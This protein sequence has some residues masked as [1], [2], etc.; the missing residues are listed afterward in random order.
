MKSFIAY[1]R[2]ENQMV[3]KLIEE[4]LNEAAPSK[5]NNTDAADV[6]EIMLGYY[7]LGGTWSNFNGSND[8]K[9]Q[10]KEKSDKVGKEVA[11]VQTK[12]AEMMAKEVIA[13][14]R[15]NGYNGKVKQVWWTARPGVL[16]KAVGQ[17]VNSR[18]NPTDVLLQ[19][20]DNEFLG[21]SAKSTKT[22]GDIGFKNPGIGTVSKNLNIVLDKF[23]TEAVNKLLKQYPDLS[24]SVSTRKREIRADKNISKTA[25]ELGTKVLNSIRDELYKKLRTMNDSDIKEYLLNDWLDAK[26]AVYPRY[27]KVTGMRNAVKIEDPMANSKVAALSSYDVSVSKIGNDSVGVM[28]GSKRIMKMRAKF[29]SQKLASSVKF[30]GDPWK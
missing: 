30:S 17:D 20:T 10:L 24:S 21:V 11:D 15:N 8:A 25:E 6:N 12:R 7:L 18:K 26:N 3:A 29:E 5:I 19:F 2:E 22:T 14:S 16:A 23:A 28:A 13:W 1:L 4:I 27:V 9:S